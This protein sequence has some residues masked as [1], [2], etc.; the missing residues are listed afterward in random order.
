MHKTRLLRFRV[1]STNVNNERPTFP[2]IPE[3]TPVCSRSLALFACERELLHMLHHP[4]PSGITTAAGKPPPPAISDAAPGWSDDAP[5]TQRVATL[6]PSCIRLWEAAEFSQVCCSA[7]RL[8]H[9]TRHEGKIKGPMPPIQRGA[10]GGLGARS[11]L[12]HWSVSGQCATAH[13]H[14]SVPH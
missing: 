10:A 7:V 12:G 4:A 8:E 14:A 6:N 9:P 11:L 1:N 5:G 2:A 13:P 3:L